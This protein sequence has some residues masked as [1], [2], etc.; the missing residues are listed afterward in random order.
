M[1]FRSRDV[2]LVVTATTLYFPFMLTQN[3][4]DIGIYT[5]TDNI[6]YETVNMLGSWEQESFNMSVP[7]QPQARVRTQVPCSVTNNCTTTF[8]ETPIT[9]YGESNGAISL[10][11]SD[12][13]SPQSVEWTGPNNFSSNNLYIGGLS[14]GSYQ[15]KITDSDCNITYASYY[16]QEP[17]SLSFNLTTINSQTNALVGCNGSASVFAQ[18]GQ[19]PYSYLWFTG[20]TSN[21]LSVTSGITGLC[22][23]VYTV[24]ITDNL[25]TIISS[26]FSITQPQ[27]LSGSVIETLNVYCYSGRTGYIKAIGVGGYAPTGYT[28]N[29]VGPVTSG[30]TRAGVV[31]FDG[32]AAGNYTI[33][34]TDSLTSTYTTPTITL[35]EPNPVGDRKST[36]LNSSHIPLSRMPSS[37]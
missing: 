18:G 3:V 13:P 30:L 9:S 10:S 23:G 16:L 37:A 33:Q 12:C 8:I 24:R 19:K 17:Q 4:E 27:P 14:S 1:L 35:V 5:D 32:L 34:I 29:L 26:I 25:G 22:A 6:Q 2:N 15:V 21:V 28:Y 31:T 36:R 7:P 20:N 11:I